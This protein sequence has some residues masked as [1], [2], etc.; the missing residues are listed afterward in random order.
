MLGGLIQDQVSTSESKVPLLGSIPLIGALFRS[1]TRQHVKTN[2]MIFIRPHVLRE[3]TAANGLTQDRYEYLRM[4][5]AA[6]QPS[7]HLILPGM[8]APQMPTVDFTKQGQ[9]PASQAPA[10]APAAA[11]GAASGVSATTPPSADA[12][13]A[14]SPVTPSPATPPSAAPPSPVTDHAAT[15]QPAAEQKPGA[16]DTPH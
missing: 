5:E 12:P 15:D 11:P 3:R 14:A 1:E 2:L 16:T 10:A 13:A 7:M 6:S 9:Q 8:T 4:E